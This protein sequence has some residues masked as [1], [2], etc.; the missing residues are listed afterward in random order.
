MTE[1]KRS[2]HCPALRSKAA[3][4]GT[5]AVSASVARLTILRGPSSRTSGLSVSSLEVTKPSTQNCSA[6]SGRLVGTRS[7][8]T[9]RGWPNQ[10][11]KLI[12]PASRLFETGRPC[13]RAG[14]R[15]QSLGRGRELPM[16]LFS[17]LFRSKISPSV[18]A[19]CPVC[20]QAL[21]NGPVCLYCGTDGDNATA[22]ILA[23]A[24]VGYLTR[25]YTHLTKSESVQAM[26]R[27][28]WL[29]C[30]DPLAMLCFLQGRA[31]G[32]KFRLFATACARDEF[33]HGTIPES[34]CPPERLPQY[35]AAI[36]A[37]EAFADGGPEPTWRESCGHWVAVPVCDVITDEDIALSALGFSADV[38]LWTTPIEEI[39]PK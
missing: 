20:Y 39:V 10:P 9:E 30:S 27:E 11:M 25:E 3:L 28:A 35:H 1:A 36:Q 33:A 12:G 37:V 13:S 15:R 31:K 24:S 6:H 17:W 4:R 29:A 22:R 18:P 7:T 38:G 5:R 23:A 8:L 26:T 19:K 21:T 34:E 14:K 32:R 16:G 2:F